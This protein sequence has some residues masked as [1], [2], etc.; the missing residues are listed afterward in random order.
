[1]NIKGRT[2]EV[3]WNNCLFCEKDENKYGY[4]IVIESQR[5]KSSQPLSKPD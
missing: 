2:P 4:G 3:Y 1:M 5:I